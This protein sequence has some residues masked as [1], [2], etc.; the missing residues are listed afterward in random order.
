MAAYGRLPRL[1]VNPPVITAGVAVAASTETVA[2]LT[3]PAWY[4]QASA[5]VAVEAEVPEDT[6]VTPTATSRVAVAEQ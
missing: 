1:H 3:T 5:A 2:T 6:V 4:S